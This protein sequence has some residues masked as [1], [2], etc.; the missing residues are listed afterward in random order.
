MAHIR[1][2]IWTN[3]D[4]SVTKKFELTYT[5]YSGKR[6]TKMF[7]LKREADAERIRIENDL[8]E[9]MHV[10]PKNSRSVIKGLRSWLSYMEGLEK[11]GKRERS[12]VDHYQTHIE[13]H[14][15]KTELASITLAELAPADIQK[16]VEHLETTLSTCMARKVYLTLSMGLKYCRKHQWLRHVPT[17]D[18]RI[19]SHDRERSGK[20]V[21]P[22]KE[23]IASLLKAA[24][25]DISGID[26]AIIRVSAF[27]GL[28]P[29]EMR[30]LPRTLLHLDTNPPTLEVAQ[31]ADLYGKIGKPKSRAGYRKIPIGP[32]TARAL[33]KTM[34]ASKPGRH[35][36]VFPNAEGGVMN[37]HNDLL[38]VYVPQE[39]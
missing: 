5:D 8:A 37:Y 35:N 18:I 29:S 11:A 24:D 22:S 13:Y 4:G 34:L 12:T 19:E 3:R 17:E 31:R 6:F 28:R 26:G 9:G 16:F 38:P 27:C 30:G 21:I 15:A 20:M 1:Q 25:Q 32:D 10:S 2:K 36:L 7:D 39:S 23:E 14:I 33:K